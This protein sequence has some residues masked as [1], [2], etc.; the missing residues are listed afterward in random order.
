MD[1]LKEKREKLQVVGIHVYKQPSLNGFL[2]IPPSKLWS[3][4][5][6]KEHYLRLFVCFV[7]LFFLNFSIR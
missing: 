3:A 4:N 5:T 7:V 1:L 2:I 6:N